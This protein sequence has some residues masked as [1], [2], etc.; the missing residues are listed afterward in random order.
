MS[1]E[2]C[3]LSKDDVS[4]A[5]LCSRA[6]CSNSPALPA[7]RLSALRAT[8]SSKSLWTS[9]WEQDC[10]QK[11]SSSDNLSCIDSAAFCHSCS[12]ASAAIACVSNLA[13]SLDHSNLSSLCFCSMV[14]T[15]S[16]LEEASAVSS[17]RSAATEPCSTSC[18]YDALALFSMAVCA[19]ADNASTSKVLCDLS[20][21]SSCCKELFALAAARH[22]STSL[23]F[24]I[25]ASCR[26]AA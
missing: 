22:S 13:S 25:F 14:T 15:A 24:S 20:V 21:V 16:L 8:C 18:S 11:A 4:A 26:L 23:R 9:S 17:E 5:F 7:S 10:L 2:R 19:L 1:S 6:S 3:W 12:L